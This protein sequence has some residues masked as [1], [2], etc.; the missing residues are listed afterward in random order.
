MVTLGGE[1]G[2]KNSS[3]YEDIFKIKCFFKTIYV[4][5]CYYKNQFYTALV[6]N[7]FVQTWM[8]KKADDLVF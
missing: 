1:G 6:V 5:L 8:L 7:R 2:S 3:S 4:F